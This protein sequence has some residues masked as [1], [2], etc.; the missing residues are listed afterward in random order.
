MFG[1]FSPFFWAAAFGLSA[2]MQ[3]ADPRY[4]KLTSDAPRRSRGLNSYGPGISPAV[5]GPHS[6]P[7]VH[8]RSRAG[9]HHW[10]KVSDWERLGGLPAI[11]GDVVE[12]V[13]GYGQVTKRER[14]P[15]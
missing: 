6:A 14:V 5:R 1:K 10:F 8:V 3:A 11:P 9:V 15:A 2:P 7:L 12:R 4:W 13:N